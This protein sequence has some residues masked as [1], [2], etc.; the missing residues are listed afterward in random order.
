MTARRLVMACIGVNL[1]LLLGVLVQLRSA[2]AQVAQPAVANVVRARVIE[3]V[4]E[5]GQMRA[6]LKVEKSGEAVFRMRDADGTIRVK[7]GASKQGAGL[8]LLDGSTEPGVQVLAGMTGTSLT[9]RDGKQ[10]QVI[11]P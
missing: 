10:Q 3:L 1:L 8:V 7:L 5:R 11:K 2:T 9:V 4:D 6:Q